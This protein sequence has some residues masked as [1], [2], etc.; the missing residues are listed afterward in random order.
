MKRKQLFTILMTIIFVFS[1]TMLAK[2]FWQGYQEENAFEELRTQIEEVSNPSEEDEFAPSPKEPILTEPSPEEIEQELLAQKLLQYAELATFNPDFV[3]W[4]K[5]NNTKIDYPVLHTPSNEEYYLHRNFEK[6]YS[7]SGTP[8]LSADNTLEADNEQIII[9]G[10]NMRNGTMF[11][12]LLFYKKQTFWE[13]NPYIYFDLLNSEDNYKI[14]AVFEM[15]VE[16]GNG[17]FPFYEHTTFENKELFDAF[18]NEVTNLS[19]Y[20]TGVVPTY[21]E[22][23]LSL[24][25]CDEYSG[26]DRIVVMGVK[27]EST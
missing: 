20:D 9:Y 8:F 7:A 12:D 27:K 11:S 14:F 22:T 4:I 21:G 19:L 2:E 15:D 25:T 6:E 1:L 23:I 26:S 16:T 3:G 24:V 10:H 17:H 13:E 18:L 5:I